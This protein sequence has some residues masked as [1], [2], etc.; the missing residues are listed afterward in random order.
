MAGTFTSK[1]YDQTV[2]EGDWAFLAPTLG[3]DP[4]VAGRD[5]WAGTILTTGADRG[6]RI[7]A[8]SGYGHGIR[9]VTTATTDVVLD[10]PS[11]TADRWDAVV[12]RRNWTTNATS[13]EV[14]KNTVE[15]NI[16]GIPAMPNTTPGGV[17][18]WPFLLAR[19]RGG[20]TRIQEI[21]DLRTRPQK[22]VVADD[23]LALPAPRYGALAMVGSTTYRGV[24]DAAASAVKW[25][26]G[27]DLQVVPLTVPAELVAWD[28]PA[29]AYY[30]GGYV[31]LEGSMKRTS[32]A[33]LNNGAPV[34]LATVPDGFRPSSTWRGVAATTAIH[35]AVNVYVESD[36]Q[37]WMADPEGS[38]VSIPYIFLGAI[39]YRVG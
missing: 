9:D 5:D 20:Q 32:N 35:K 29:A 17:H 1:G 23:L 33:N 28:T 19:A 15:S 7:A 4:G 11:G 24:Y 8:G 25:R 14:V 10:A 3:G 2:Q 22:V 6:L 37:V 12:V 16:P 13:F 34:L 31:Q 27:W 26:P 30:S 36:G 21:R 38:G 39:R 18:D